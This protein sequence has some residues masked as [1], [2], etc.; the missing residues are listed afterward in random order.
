[1]K[2]TGTE[3]KQLTSEIQDS[4]APLKQLTHQDLAALLGAAIRETTNTV[5]GIENRI[6]DAGVMPGDIVTI[7]LHYGA[8]HAVL[9]DLP[10]DN[11]RRELVEAGEKVGQFIAKKYGEK[12]SGILSERSGGN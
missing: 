12:I 9:K 6:K 11:E 2:I 1:M 4:C 5:A 7:L 10:A 3:A 8:V